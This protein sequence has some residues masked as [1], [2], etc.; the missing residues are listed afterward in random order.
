MKKIIAL[1]SISLITSFAAFSQD[2]AQKTTSKNASGTIVLIKTDLGDI[3]VKLFNETPIHRDNFIKLASEGKYDGSIFHRVIP[4][5]MI[6]GGGT[7]SGTQSIGEEIPAEIKT[8]YIHKRGALAAARMGDDVNPMKK[9]SGSQFYI[10]QGRTF[11]E[12][13]VKAIGQRAGFPYSEEQIQTYIKEGGAPHLDGGYTVFGEVIEGM[14]VV[15]KIA[16]AQANNTRP[17]QEIKMTVKIL[18]K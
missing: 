16:A 11:T 14:D 3:K 12:Q 5:F 18:K 17:I 10:V 2:K 6:Q 15:D 7:N 8:K 1:L 13:D 4:Q 9:S